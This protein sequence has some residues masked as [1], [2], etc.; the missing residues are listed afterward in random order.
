MQLI[1]DITKVQEEKRKAA[2]DL[3]I[4]LQPFIIAVGLSKADIS[5]IFISVDDTL[6]KVLS[7]LKAIDLC[8]KIFQVFDV[9]YP[10]ES[11]HI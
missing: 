2:A 8:F 5:D 4:T 6:Y 1:A 9:E 3:G 10:I 11:T 7:A